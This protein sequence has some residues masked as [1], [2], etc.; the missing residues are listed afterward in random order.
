MLEKAGAR[1]R[2]DDPATLLEIVF[3][4]IA[5]IL[6]SSKRHSYAAFLLGL[7]Q[8]ERDEQARFR[9]DDLAPFSKHAVELLRKVL[10]QL[11]ASLFAQRMQ[12]CV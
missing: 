12:C 6:D 4:P 8:L 3:R 2:L 10:P 9:S 11:P 7:F 5:E 1:G